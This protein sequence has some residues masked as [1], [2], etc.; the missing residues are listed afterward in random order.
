MDLG[1]NE[2]SWS[3]VLKDLRVVCNLRPR[4]SSS[5]ENDVEWMGGFGS[6]G[7]MVQSIDWR[8]RGSLGMKERRGG[9]GMEEV[10]FPRMGRVT[11]FWGG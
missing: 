9:N 5:V 8:R 7:C 6:A 2:K 3:A 4:V 11:G 10:R 1:G